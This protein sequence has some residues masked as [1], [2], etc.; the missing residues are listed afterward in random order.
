MQKN[1][2]F[3]LTKKERELRGFVKLVKESGAVLSSYCSLA[4]RAFLEQSRFLKIATVVPDSGDDPIFI[5]L[6]FDEELSGMLSAYMERNRIKT[7]S[8]LVKMILTMSVSV[9]QESVLIPEFELQQALYS[10][11]AATRPVR[12]ET[13]SSRSGE[14]SVPVK[15][16]PKEKVKKEEQEKTVLDEEFDG[17]P[18]PEKSR[19]EADLLDNL[20]AGLGAQMD[21]W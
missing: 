21:K 6:Y 2:A 20:F 18:E 16:H 19:A 3:K 13:I 4:L 14:S 7:R 1:F 9:G 8:K 15:K 17:M 11:E 10:A 5:N 12:V